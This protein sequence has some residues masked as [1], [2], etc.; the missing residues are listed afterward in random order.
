[1]PDLPPLP[2]GASFVPPLPKG[3]TFQGAAPAPASPSAQPS[4]T[5]PGLA[6]SFT[7]GLAPIA[8]G[9]GVGAALG[10]PFA[11]VGAVPGAIAG[12][13]AAGVSEFG[14][15]IYN[16]AARVAGY[17]K[18]QITTLQ[19]A[20][21]KVLD[22]LGLRRPS[23]GW[24]KMAETVGGAAPLG[25]TAGGLGEAVV[26]NNV[27]KVDR[28]IKSAYERAIK[29]TSVNRSTVS[30]LT[31]SRQQARGAIDSIV[32]NKPALRFTD[33]AGETR[34][35]LPKTIEQFA[36][37][38]DQTKQ[39]VFEKYDA[40]AKQAGQAGA[41]VALHP[42][43]AEL[44]KIATDPV[45]RDLH[46]ELAVYAENT[47]AR[48]AERGFYST[49]DAQRA[50]QNLNQSLKAFYSNPTYETASRASVD[51]MV[52]NQFRSGLDKAIEGATG[53]GYQALK[54][55]YGA[56]RSI[57]K[58]VV[59][60]S[61]VEGRKNLGGGLM[62]NIGDLVSADEVI[63]GIITLN[64]AAIARGTGM[65]L[66][67]SFVK[68]MRDPN[69]S[70]EKLFE[71][72]ENQKNV[73]EMARAAL[74]T[75]SSEK[76][77][78]L[79]PP[80]VSGPGAP[81]VRAGEGLMPSGPNFKMQHPSP[82]SISEHPSVEQIKKDIQ[83]VARYLAQRQQRALPAPPARPLLPPP[84]TIYGPQYPTISTGEGIIPGTNPAF[85]TTPP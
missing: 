9:A 68:K 63:R 55:E 35:E 32:T 50:I 54:N 22:K 61:I 13:T 18:A 79:P 11:G 65:K 53:P 84:G 78:A 15:D 42:T 82:S 28:F 2:A 75:Y 34:G 41:R 49:V 19:D 20:M 33:A 4:T 37:A 44:Q 30:Q 57:E 14:S 77:L 83:T 58:D 64:P 27:G 46:P 72:A 40:M 59:K 24:E 73:Q 17:P 25:L 16:A 23:S 47:A 38:I 85:T 10:A 66:F 39:S 26:E 21:D 43:V 6:A 5:L 67:T 56:L 7:R 71:A 69:R 45:V 36:D 80:T 76:P 29:P 74:P 12:G 60:R 81:W 3:A 70:V 8:A 51:A 48:L 52:A 1:M 62:G 31:Q